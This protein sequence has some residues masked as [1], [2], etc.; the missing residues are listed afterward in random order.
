MQLSAIP[1][2]L[3]V[4]TISRRAIILHSYKFFQL[5]VFTDHAFGGN[6]LAVFPEAEGISDEQMQQI[7]REM[8]LWE[9]LFVPP[10]AKE[11]SLRRLLL[12][13][14]GSE[15]PSA[16]H[17][18][19]GTWNCLAREGVV[20][21]PEGGSG[22]VHLKHEVGIGVLPIE[23]EFKDGAPMRVVMTQGQFEIRG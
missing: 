2:T 22:S 8:H 20:T 7:A 21:P 10:P 23:I 1:K 3:G 4:S 5:D 17:P 15:L 14:P 13:T 9:T 19:V 6:P 16:G 12:L 18:I 11:E